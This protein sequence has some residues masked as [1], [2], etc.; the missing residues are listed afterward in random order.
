MHLGP[1]A[2]EFGTMWFQPYNTGSDI[3]TPSCSAS[4]SHPDIVF[5]LDLPPS[6]A[7]E[8]VHGGSSS[9]V[10]RELRRGGECPGSVPVLCTSDTKNLV[11][12]NGG[13]STERLYYI[14]QSASRSALSVTPLVTYT[15]A[16]SETNYCY[17]GTR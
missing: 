15:G 16:P 14:V 12:E 7:V 1:H 8:L 2:T 11:Y 9:T 13:S 17:G 4:T 5:S 6:H 3:L 10:V